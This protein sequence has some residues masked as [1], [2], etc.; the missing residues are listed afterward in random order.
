M[1][2]KF[3]QWLNN[4]KNKCIE[5][6]YKDLRYS[7]NITELNGTVYIKYLYDA[8]YKMKPTDTIQDVVAKLEEF[9]S[10]AVEYEANQ[11]KI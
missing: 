4:Y 10:I 2:K 5:K 11:N 8:I 9:R 3:K 1:N 7:F 6:K